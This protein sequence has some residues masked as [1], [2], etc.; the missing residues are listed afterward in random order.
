MPTSLDTFAPYDAGA[1][2]DVTEDTW[3]KFM[4]HMLGSGADGILRNI[5]NDFEVF[6]DSSGLQVKVKTGECFIRSQ[7]GESTSQKTLAIA[8]AD[9]TDPRK[10]RV[11]LR[12]DFVD[13]V[14]ELDVL[15]GTPAASP[16]TPSLTQNTSQWE[17]SLAVVDVAAGAT[18]IAAG[19]VTDDRNYA[20]PMHRARQSTAQTF[21]TGTQTKVEFDGT[22]D[23]TSAGDV[24]VSGTGNVDFTLKRAGLWFVS[25]NIVFNSGT[26]N[27]RFLAITDDGNTVRYTA[28]NN[29]TGTA[30]FLNC[31][32]TRR[33]AVDD[34]L[35]VHALQ[36]SGANLDTA[37]GT[38]N[39]IW[40]TLEW[41]AP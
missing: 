21:S 2:A 16:T 6:G 23:H 10:D 33:F 30:S 32:T 22:A 15:T 35:S 41:R 26:A 40:F 37:P 9:P 29:N 3:R 31:S 13:N 39:H 28:A 1:G 25:A 11:I 14:V 4:R 20:I 5:A 7:W 27:E 34:V 38:L 8:T 12:N 36:S 19:D 17:T 24:V 18:T